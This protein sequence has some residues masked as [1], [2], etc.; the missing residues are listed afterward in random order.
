M[1]RTVD[2]ETLKKKKVAEL[3]EIAKT[4]G[5][6]GYQK[7]KKAELVEA[8]MKKEDVPQPEP[9]AAAEDES[10]SKAEEEPRT[11]KTER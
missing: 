9:L 11:K 2:E 7:M 6:E 1:W 3:K 5:L 4:F 10:D 8:L